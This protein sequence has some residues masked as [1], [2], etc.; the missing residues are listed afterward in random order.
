M[1]FIDFQKIQ[2]CVGVK[3][4]MKRVY[5]FNLIFKE[6]YDFYVKKGEGL[7][8]KNRQDFYLM[9]LFYK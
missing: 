3:Y 2:F 9:F 4:F 5:R 8:V 7:C 1:I 6:I